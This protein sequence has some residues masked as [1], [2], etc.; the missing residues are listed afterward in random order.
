MF[1]RFLDA[2]D[3]WFGYSDNSS[4][5]SYDPARECFVM[6]ANNQETPRTRWKPAT[7]RSPSTPE[8]DHTR[9]WVRTMC[10]SRTDGWSL[11]CV[12]SD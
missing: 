4:A 1:Q 10:G 5:G 7:E 3:Y 6:I 12:M 9:A 2:A 8:L 11:P